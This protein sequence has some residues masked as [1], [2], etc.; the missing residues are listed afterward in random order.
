MF[1]LAAG[2]PEQRPGQAKGHRSET[3]VGRIEATFRRT[4]AKFGCNHGQLIPNR[5]STVFTMNAMRQVIPLHGS[6]T[7]P[8]TSIR[9]PLASLCE[10]TSTPVAMKTV[11]PGRAGMPLTESFRRNACPDAAGRVAQGSRRR[12]APPAA[13]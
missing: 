2:I 5:G 3:N 8:L 7:R 10:R 1:R 6:S 13:R 11:A 12:R 9:I 4:M